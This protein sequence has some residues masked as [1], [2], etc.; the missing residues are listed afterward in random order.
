MISVSL[1]T[2]HRAMNLELEMVLSVKAEY[3]RHA[4]QCCPFPRAVLLHPGNFE[5]LGWVEFLG[6][7]VLADDRVN[8]KRAKLICGSGVGGMHNGLPVYWDDKGQ[9][10]LLALNAEAA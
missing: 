8:P 10:W 4:E 1:G 3:E 7:P 5:L 6:L 2:M 9:P